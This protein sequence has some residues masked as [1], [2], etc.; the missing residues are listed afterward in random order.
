MFS[1]LGM[2]ALGA[3]PMGQVD[4]AAPSPEAQPWL[5]QEDDADA[6]RRLKELLGKARSKDDAEREEAAKGLAGF[7]DQEAT[8]ALLKLGEDDDVIVQLAALRGLSGRDSNLAPKLFVSTALGSPFTAVRREA[9]TAFASSDPTLDAVYGLC[10]YSMQA[11]SFAGIYVDG[12]RERIPYE[13][14]AYLNQLTHYAVDAE[15]TL[16]RRSLEYLLQRPTWPTEWPMHSVLMAGADYDATGDLGTARAFYDE[17]LGKTLW[18]LARA[19]GLISTEDGRVTREFLASIGAGRLADIVDWPP[20]ERDGYDLRPYNTVVNAVHYRAL[21]DMARLAQALGVA[22]DAAALSARADQV[23][24][25]FQSAFFDPTTGLYVDGEGSTH[26]SQHANLFPL[27]FGLVPGAHVP[28]VLAFVKQRRLACSVYAAQ[29]LLEALCLHGEAAHAIELMT[30]DSDRGWVN[31]MRGGS[32]VTL[33][34]WDRRYKGNLD[35]NHAWGAAPGNIL[36]RFVL[37]VTPAEPG[38]ARARIQPRP[39]GLTRVSGRVPTVRGEVGV[40]YEGTP[41]GYTLTVTLPANVPADVVLPDGT[42][43]GGAAGVDVT[44]NGE[45]VL[46]DGAPV[47][48]PGGGVWQFVVQ[49]RGGT[50]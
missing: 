3:S 2:I 14:D 9:T 39:G 48:L 37:G 32:T 8:T 21:R 19:D 49:T 36:P 12:D 41:N 47:V 13:A 29:Y 40:A 18:G 16:A 50:E 25:S 15:F 5:V 7:P 26:S 24:A 20:G 4:G 17:L 43:P 11:T 27:A 1:A 31:M 38:Y 6:E 30:N 28:G 42:R 34:A 44:L 45:A 46:A 23:A 35:W 33:E 10:R 22:D